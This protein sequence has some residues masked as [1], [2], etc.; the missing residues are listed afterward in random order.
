MTQ[1]LVM[2]F[3][4]SGSRVLAPYRNIDEH[5]GKT[6]VTPMMT[7]LPHLLPSHVPSL[8][9]L[10]LGGGRRGNKGDPSS[11]EYAL[12]QPRRSQEAEKSLRRYKLNEWWRE[13]PARHE[14]NPIRSFNTLT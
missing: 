14:M 6:H 2:V 11:H 13:E 9:T 10:V 8:A 12:M 3:S 1:L 7:R 4:A 5:V